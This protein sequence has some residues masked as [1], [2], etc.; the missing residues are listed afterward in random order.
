MSL[1][2]QVLG[3]QANI[4]SKLKKESNGNNL[5]YQLSKHKRGLKTCI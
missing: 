5:R 4:V 2:F 1:T 3:H